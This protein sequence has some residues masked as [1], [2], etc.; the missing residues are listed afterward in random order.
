MNIHPWEI[1]HPIFEKAKKYD[2]VTKMQYLDI[3]TWL[4]GNILMKA[5]KMTMANS[6]ELRVPFIDLKVFE[7]AAEIPTKYKIAKG[8]T[9]YVL[10]EAMKDI[11]PEEIHFRKKWGFPVPIRLWLKDEY[12]KWAK[13]L[14]CE[15]SVEDW[16]N[17]EFAL[18]LLADHKDGKGDYSRK[19]WTILIFILWHQIYIE[20][21][22]QFES[23]D[24]PNVKKHRYLFV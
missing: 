9:K 14:I 21:K 23:T 4:R 24:L 12:Y 13:D 20:K 22:Y 5:D 2:D 17:K 8:T 16:I 19:I 11:L 7:A 1:T 6:L 3:H 15:S 10:R 18:T